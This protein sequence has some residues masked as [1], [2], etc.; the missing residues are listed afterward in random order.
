MEP[1]RRGGTPG[2]APDDITVLDGG[3]VAFPAMLEA[4]EAAR[5]EILL[6]VYTFTLGTV[7]GRFAAALGRAVQRG[8]RVRI[9]I[10]GWGS[11]PH[12]G[13]VAARLRAAGCE[14]EIFNPMSRLLLG[15]LRRNHRKMLA[16][17]GVLAIVG[18]INVADEYLAAGGLPAPWADLAVAVRGR[19]AAWL[20]RRGRGERGHSPAGPVR[21]WLSGLGG[22]WRLRRRYV[23]AIG[24]ARVHLL[25]AHAY[26][27]PDRHL[28]RS[29]T[30]AARRGV[31]VQIVLP[32]RSDV[33]LSH[34]AARRH[35]RRL[36][37]AGVEVYEWPLSMLHAKIAVVD[38]LRLLIGSFNLDPLSLANL[39]ALAEVEDRR[40]AAEGERWVRARIAESQRIPPG[41]AAEGGI[42]GWWRRLTGRAFAAVTGWLARLI[43]RR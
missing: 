27:L 33:L 8:V 24:G 16:I 26:F 31:R 35:Y 32:A 43:A 3:A 15:R 18:G 17:D 25:L 14:V 36:L 11:A 19:A 41:W 10:D 9:V 38:G 5:S 40:A 4:I 22:G 21:F 29:I 6:E 30:A 39:E 1:A 37:A 34:A 23:K 42:A 12:A 7:G 13:A 2:R 28:V 20:Q